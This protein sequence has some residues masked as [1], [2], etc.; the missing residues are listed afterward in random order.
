MQCFIKNYTELAKPLFPAMIVFPRSVSFPRRTS[1]LALA[2]LIC[3]VL[4]TPRLAAAPLA[5]SAE[6]G[7]QAAFKAAS[8]EGAPVVLGVVPAD[9]LLLLAEAPA[10]AGTLIF[11]H[12]EAVGEVALAFDPVKS[13]GKIS[14]DIK[15]RP[16]TLIVA[17]LPADETEIFING[18]H[19]GRGAVTLG[20]VAPREKIT[21]EA[22]SA[23]RGM[24]SRVV[25][26]EPGESLT[27]KFDLRGNE[28]S[29]RPDGQIVLPELPLVLASQPGATMKSDG[30]PVVPEEGVLRGLAPGERV[31]EIFLPWRGREVCVWRGALPARSAMLPGADVV[32]IPNPVSSAPA[33]AAAAAP[34]AKPA[35]GAAATAGTPP[36]ASGKAG[37][38]LLVVGQSVAVS[39]GANAGLENG[40]TTRV[41]FGDAAEP[42]SVAVSGVTETQSFL[43]LPD[44]VP[45][46]AP[47]ASCRLADAPRP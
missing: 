40:A 35:E 10:S 36:P 2:A 19:R 8:A 16:A 47:G 3:A 45:V 6:P 17:A 26:A 20:G 41:F 43:R 46:P 21:V 11:T 29:S 33:P 9:G 37:E 38:V 28:I 22:R 42:V 31:V 1:F 30:V 32:A 25:S 12:P 5:V 15:L 23:R 18:Q 7:T 27:V 13:P 4:F 34:E 24:Q 14:P 44:D 39:F